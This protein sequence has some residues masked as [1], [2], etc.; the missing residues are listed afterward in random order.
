MKTKIN[1]T[2]NIMDEAKQL[3]SKH[4][5]PVYVIKGESSDNESEKVA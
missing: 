3:V 1:D 5:C 2:T 4:I